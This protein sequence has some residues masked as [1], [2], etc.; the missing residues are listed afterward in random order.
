MRHTTLL[1]L[2]EVF[3]EAVLTLNG[4]QSYE[5]HRDAVWHRVHQ[6]K[7][8]PS[9]A[10]RTFFLRLTPGE[11]VG[12]D[13]FSGD[14]WDQ[15]AILEIWTS[16]CGLEDDEDGPIIDEDK[17][18]LYCLFVDLADPVNDGLHPVKLL[19]WTYEIDEPGKVYG[20][21]SFLVRYLVAD[22][23]NPDEPS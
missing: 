10:A 14:G 20:Y 18:Q 3:A 6:I 4:R 8:V 11:V 22:T 9:T 17:R 2:R 7:D 19:P 5:D 16:Y 12:E 13:G 15:E 23:L 21:H 1:R